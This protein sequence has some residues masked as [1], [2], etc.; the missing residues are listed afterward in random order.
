LFAVPD[1]NLPRNERRDAHRLKR[2]QEI[3]DTTMRLVDSVDEDEVGDAKF[4]ECAKGRRGERRARRIGVDNDDGDVGDGEPPSSISRKSNR[5]R[6]IEDGERI[7]EI[8]E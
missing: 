1:G 3:A 5:S 8:L 7:A 2:R 6:R 4:V